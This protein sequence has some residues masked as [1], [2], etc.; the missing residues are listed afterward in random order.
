MEQINLLNAGVA[1]LAAIA[2]VAAA[3]IA[4]AA[5][6][7]SQTTAA[8]ARR[9]TADAKKEAF[10]R[11]EAQDKRNLTLDIWKLWLSADYRA[12]R[13]DAWKAL[14][15]VAFGKLET[16]RPQLAPILYDTAVNRAVGSIEHFFDEVAQLRRAGLLDNTVFDSLFKKTSLS[17]AGLLYKFDRNGA[18]AFS[19]EEISAALTQLLGP[20]HELEAREAYL[21]AGHPPR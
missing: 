11:E 21:R 18:D 3:V 13:V 5:Y 17:W 19:E 6:N 8:R 15:A 20:S 2:S 7:H 16:D 10:E 9:D 4:G 12:Y 1:L 14:H